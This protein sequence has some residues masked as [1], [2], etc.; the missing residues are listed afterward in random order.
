VAVSVPVTVRAEQFGSERI[1]IPADRQ[2]LLDPSVLAAEVEQLNL[3]FGRQTPERLWEGLFIWPHEGEITSPFGMSRSYN[4]IHSGYH[5]GVDIT[6]GPGAPVV[7]ANGGRVALA[8][9]LQVRGNAVV[10]DHGCGLLSAYYHLSEIT[11]RE[12]Q[13]VP[14]GELLGRLGNTGLSTGAHLH[15]EMRVGGIMVD[16]IEWTTTMIPEWQ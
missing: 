10:L 4:D 2:G 1:D 7:A 9:P 8:E 13:W 15:W 3:V 5:G 6:G 16:P 14:K 11:V 12:D